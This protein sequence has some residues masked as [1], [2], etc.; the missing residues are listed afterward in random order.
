MDKS[1]FAL[2]MIEVGM[3]ITQKTCLIRLPSPPTLPHLG[4]HNKPTLTFSNTNVM[5]PILMILKTNKQTK[6]TH[7]SLLK[8]GKEKM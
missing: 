7:L 2:E 4:N 3:R 1:R 5:I 8:R 6:I